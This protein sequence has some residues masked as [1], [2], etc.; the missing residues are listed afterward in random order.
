MVYYNSI[1]LKKKFDKFE[2]IGDFYIN[3]KIIKNINANI[4]EVRN[5]WTFKEK[6]KKYQL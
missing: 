5:V 1:K 3:D 2:F 6:E 4:E